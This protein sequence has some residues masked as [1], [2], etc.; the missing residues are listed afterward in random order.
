MNPFAPREVRRRL[1]AGRFDVAHA[2]LGVVSPFATDLVPV[3]L[4][5]GLPVTATFHCVIGRSAGVF[6]A[7]GH[8]LALGRAWRRA[9]RGVADGGRPG[10]R[11]RPRCRRRGGAERRGCR[12]VAS[13]DRAR[14]GGH[15]AS[16]ARRVGDAAG[17][18][19]ATRWPR[20]GCCAAPAA[21]LDPAVPLRATIVGEGPQR[22]LMERYLRTHGLDWVE[23]PGRV[24]KEELRRLHQRRGRLPHLR[25]ARGLRHRPARGAGRRGAG[26][27]ARAAPGSTTSSRTASTGCSADGDAGARGRAGPPGRRRRPAGPDARS[28]AGHPSRAGLER[29]ARRHPGRVPTGR[30]CS[31]RD[32]RRRQPRRPAGH[33]LR[34]RAR[35]GPRGGPGRAR[36]AGRRSWGSRACS[37]TSP[38]GTPCSRPS[39]STR[40]S[41]PEGPGLTDAERLGVDPHQRVAAYAVVVADGPAAADPAGRPHRCGQAGGTCPAAGSTPASRPPRAWSGRWPRRPGRSSTRCGWST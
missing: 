32:H 18:A 15:P 1:A 6:R 41:G 27:R 9:Q 13:G 17:V 21:M 36:L 2:H 7:L 16:G 25:A 29:R 8:L 30:G 5:A 34:A 22:R 19:Q 23:L 33:P 38:C 4:D 26:G 11:R 31:P 10:V 24:D 20:W 39:R 3:A 12:V 28:P 40:R 37:A 14:R 35:R